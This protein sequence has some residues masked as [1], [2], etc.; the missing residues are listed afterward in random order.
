M[1]FLHVLGA[2][3][4]VGGQLTVSAILLP[5]ARMRLV[6][7]ERTAL[8]TAVGRRFALLTVA[9]FVPLQV[10]TGWLLAVHHE[11]TWQALLEPGYGRTLLVK[12]VLFGVVMVAAAAHG[13]AQS[14]GRL[15]LSRTASILTLVASLAVVWVATALAGRHP[16]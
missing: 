6:P 11:V 5:A 13:I 16:H 7:A 2:I 15:R 3:V 14:R 10:A 4:W 8:L 1:R 9:G 12:L